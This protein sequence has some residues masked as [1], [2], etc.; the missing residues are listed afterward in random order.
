M[1]EQEDYSGNS[2]TGDRA[3]WGPVLFYVALIAVLVF[4]WWMV[5]YPHGVEG[6]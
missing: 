4:F 5:I 3:T 1:S 2:H 6:H